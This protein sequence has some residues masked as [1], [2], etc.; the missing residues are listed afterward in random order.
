MRKS[1][2]GF[3]LFGLAALAAIPS[4]RA[5][6]QAS[7]SIIRGA[8]DQISVTEYKYVV[9][10]LET[11]ANGQKRQDTFAK[12]VFVAPDGRS[13]S[14][15]NDPDG[16]EMEVINDPRSHIAVTLDL[17]HRT[18]T[19]FSHVGANAGS[20]PKGTYLDT[21]TIQ[22]MLCKG[23]KSALN[24]IV[25]E[26]WSFDDPSGANLNARFVVR[27]P[28]GNQWSENLAK[29]I[30]NASLSESFFRVPPGFSV[31]DKTQ[32]P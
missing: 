23:Y 18:A 5:Q 16:G 31:T 26:A 11:E 25:V 1:T 32:N 19:R 2:I 20:A 8:P 13:L 22:G 28:D 7:V 4:A 12:H 14:R 3:L 29:V 30:H 10:R 6:K 15:Y 27:L 17:T 9:T 24:G 21:R